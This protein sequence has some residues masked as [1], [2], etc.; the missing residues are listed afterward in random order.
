MLCV[1]INFSKITA[2]FGPD[3]DVLINSAGISK[4]RSLFLQTKDL[5][6]IKH[7][8]NVN[9][10]GTLR[11]VQKVLK[12]MY[13][14]QR[15]KIINISS[16]AAQGGIAACIDHKR[17]GRHSRISCTIFSVNKWTSYYRRPR[18]D[19]SETS[20]KNGYPSLKI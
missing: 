14:R 8:M 3:I 6:N 5:D 2:H 20:I 16:I 15:G 4:A 1:E 17:G 12:S 7:M 19:D 13:S 11:M 10:L 18:R 9:F